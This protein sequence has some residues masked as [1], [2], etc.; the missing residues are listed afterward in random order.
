[1]E[2]QDAD[3]Q[4]L[5]KITPDGKVQVTMH[6]TPGK[7]PLSEMPRLGMRMILPAEYE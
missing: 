3:L 5:Y 1:M 6:F 2:E 4:T 7:K